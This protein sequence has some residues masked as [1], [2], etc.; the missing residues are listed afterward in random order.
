MKNYGAFAQRFKETDALRGNYVQ[1]TDKRGT[2]SGWVL[3]IVQ[4]N[5]FKS[6]TNDELTGAKLTLGMVN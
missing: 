6:S 3:Q 4:D 2:Q 1:V 5:Q